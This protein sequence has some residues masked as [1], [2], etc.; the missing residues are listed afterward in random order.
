VARS[1]NAVRQCRA[2][3]PRRAAAVG[4]AGAGGRGGRRGG[5]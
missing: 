1:R 5:G 3:Q 4:G 2:G